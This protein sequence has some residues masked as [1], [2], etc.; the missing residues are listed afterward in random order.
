MNIVVKDTKEKDNMKVDKKF[1]NRYKN[2]KELL[3]TELN[4]SKA[5]KRFNNKI[6]INK[7]IVEI[8]EKE[9]LKLTLTQLK[10]ISI[11][12]FRNNHESNTFQ[13]DGNNIMINNEDIKE[14][15]KKILGD[16][17][18]KEHLIEHLK[19]FSKLGYVI[20]YGKLV[21]ESMEQKARQNY[22]SWHYYV[23]NI[24]IGKKKFLLEF[25][26]VSRNDG[27]N[28]YRIQRLVPLDYEKNKSPNSSISSKTMGT[29]SVRPVSTEDNT[30]I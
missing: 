7:N 18:Q 5:Q 30:T 14:S 6:T 23:E 15:I 17:R 10:K 11:E 24:I 25:D 26:V 28:H 19:V 8:D 13:N 21:S 12:I 27:E 1:L 3:I 9:L 20:K 4:K 22:N 2:T 29:A 16:K